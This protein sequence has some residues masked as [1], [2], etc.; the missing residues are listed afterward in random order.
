MTSFIT[1]DWGT[2]NFRA[3][4]INEENKVIDTISNDKGMMQFEKD[5]FHGFLIQELSSWLE[6]NHKIKIYMSGMVGSMNGWLET[7]YLHCDVS[8]DE[9]S[10]NLIPI[11]NIKEEIY[12][13]PG[14]KTLKNGLIDL[15][16]GEEVQIFGALKEASINNAVLILPGT[17]SKWAK[18]CDEKILDF[19]TNMTGE[20]FNTLSTNTILSKSISNKE[21][22]I[23]AFEK[24]VALSQEK[25]GLLNQ[26]FQARAQ[27]KEIGED[28][29][30]SFLSGILIGH[31][32]KEMSSLFET[33]EVLIVGNSTL[34]TLYENALNQYD[35]KSK[36]IDSNIATVNAM[37]Y[38]NK[39]QKA[40]HV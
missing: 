5:E 31:E 27:A 39:K 4:L 20:V 11:P 25:G 28:N 15:M 30:Y 29:I 16:R 17:H 19:K 23:K 22:N 32:I 36:T 40:T 1:V 33:K 37:T 6:Q 18:V 3:S 26:V 35:M 7:I 24:G 38:I 14:V 34:N 13:V 12:I 9:L 10:Q 8:L 2:T 21:I